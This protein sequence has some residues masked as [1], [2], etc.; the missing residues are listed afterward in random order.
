M[1]ISAQTHKYF[2]INLQCYIKHHLDSA[3]KCRISGKTEICFKDRS[4]KSTGLKMKCTMV[5]KMVTHG[6][7]KKYEFDV[8]Y[9]KKLDSY[10]IRNPHMKFVG[11]CEIVKYDEKGQE[12]YSWQ[13][14]VLD[15][16]DIFANN[17]IQDLRNYA[18]G[19]VKYLYDD[20]NMTISPIYKIEEKQE[21]KKINKDSK[22]FLRQGTNYLLFGNNADEFESFDIGNSYIEDEENQYPSMFPESKNL[23]FNKSGINASA[24]PAPIQQKGNY[25]KQ[26]NN[27]SAGLK[28][29]DAKKKGD[30]E[31]K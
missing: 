11:K 23:M 24:A 2:G 17:D 31:K 26:S 3:K 4:E 29:R 14:C 7:P 19:E 25:N 28:Q 21:E 30:L 9:D 12:D 6:I 8:L 27:S 20:T 10:F 15:A 16:K 1:D 13:N 18:A 5:S 22:D